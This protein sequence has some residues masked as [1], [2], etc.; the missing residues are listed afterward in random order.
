M[1]IKRK[2]R[3]EK[4][5]VYRM[6]QRFQTSVTYKNFFNFTLDGR[7]RI[8][9]FGMM[10]GSSQLHFRWTFQGKYWGQ[11]KERLSFKCIKS[12]FILLVILLVDFHGRFW[13]L[14]S[15]KAHLKGS[16]SKR[17]NQQRPL[18]GLMTPLPPPPSCYGALVAGQ[19]T[20]LEF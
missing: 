13:L 3:T 8:Y 9:A 4:A 6:L 11:Y 1:F 12:Y 17:A 2:T 15:K 7:T 14:L 20:D 18:S 10:F 16:S 5:F 19:A